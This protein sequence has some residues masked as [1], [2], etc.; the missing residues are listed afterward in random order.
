[1]ILAKKLA[2]A[3][4]AAVA[5]TVT[6]VGVATAVNSDKARV[7]RVID[8][9]TLV[10]DFK[11]EE[12][13]VRLLNVDTPETKDPNEPVECLGPEAT[14]FLKEALPQGRKVTLAFDVE[15][16]DRYG[17]TLAAVY[18]AKDRLINAEVARQGFG[19]PVT[20]GK[21]SKFRPPV[22]AA[23]QEAE[24]QKKGLFDDNVECTVP[25]TVA[26]LE[27]A[28]QE[29]AAQGTGTSAASAA[30]AAAAVF[31]AAKV[32]NEGFDALEAG[33]KTGKSVIW[34]VLS[35]ADRSALLARAATAKGTIAERHGELTRLQEERQA[36]EDEAKRLEAEAK[37]EAERVAAE[38]EARKV[39]EAAQAEAD[40]IAAAQAEAQRI[41]AAQAE[42][43]RRAQQQQY[44]APPQQQ[45]AP[46]AQGNPSG[47]T[48][49]RCYAPG[50]KT[51]RPC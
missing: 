9:D 1:M 18:D 28:V 24:E 17:R 50:G 3:A 16:L 13:T 14:E 8:G 35:E 48:G 33:A 40:R 34:K 29:A 20:Y 5:I 36:A 4:T 49:P 26:A 7:V 32:V 42:A 47:Y 31:A 45:Y 44:V 25:G 46:P 43:N 10:V 2:I 30:T 6:S 19:I 22:D 15:L 41:A 21:N 38:E 37:A 39:A 27:S 51:W 11:N 12:L 23:Y